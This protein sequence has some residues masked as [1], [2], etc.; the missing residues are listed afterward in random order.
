MKHK[1][2]IL[3]KINVKTI[4]TNIPVEDAEYLFLA[5]TLTAERGEDFMKEAQEKFPK[6]AEWKE[7]KVC[8]PSNFGDFVLFWVKA[9]ILSDESA[10]TTIAYINKGIESFYRQKA[11]D[12]LSE[13]NPDDYVERMMKI[14]DAGLRAMKRESKRQFG[15]FEE[16]L[17]DGEVEQG[18]DLDSILDQIEGGLKDGE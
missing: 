6:L 12:I 7:V 3:S 13:E 5:S 14:H 1:Y 16:E 18:S 4:A 10:I 11:I 17:S 2:G 8:Y 15:A 9:F